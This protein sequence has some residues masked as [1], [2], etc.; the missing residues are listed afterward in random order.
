LRFFLGIVIISV[1]IFSGS[2]AFA[3]QLSL[4]VKPTEELKVTIDE[5]G[6]A[7]VTHKVN[8][9]SFKPI[10]VNLIAG[11]MTNFV[12]TD[13]N[14]STVQYGTA[15]YGK[16]ANSPISI[17]LDMSVRNV[18]MI[19][20]DLP[21]AV[22]NIDGVWAWNYYEPTDTDHT[23]FYFPKG[24]DVIWAN[25]RPVYLGEHGLRQHGNGFSL[26][27]II[28]ETTNIQNVQWQDK[29]FPVGIRTILQ[30]GNYVF[31]QSQMTYAFDVDKPN[32]P[33]TVIMPKE[34]LWGPYQLTSHQ[35][36]TSPITMYH[37]N[38]THAWIGLVPHRAE[39]IDIRG[40]TAIP[41]FPMFI[42][43]A[44]ALTIVILV[45]FTRLNFH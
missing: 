43:L 15:Q 22:T 10:Q 11:N 1:L 37:E 7:H 16:V 6:N 41:E 38:Q 9:I 3:Q 31:D 35:N 34:L 44:I 28:N 29:N 5:S 2:Q 42:P 26:R 12:V 36:T 4:G 24:V 14:G 33:I 23:D 13:I 25:E 30:P 19:K 18:T 17:I 45:R 40:T 8:G 27:Y 39:T 21:N 32:V 20:Y